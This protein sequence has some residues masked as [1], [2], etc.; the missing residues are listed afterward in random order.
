VQPLLFDS[1]H[2]GRNLGLLVRLE[3]TPELYSLRSL[4]NLI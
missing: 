4:E 2:I 3:P 1:G